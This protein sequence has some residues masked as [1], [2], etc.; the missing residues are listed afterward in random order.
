MA[1]KNRSVETID[2]PQFVNLEPV[3]VNPLM[4]KCD[5]KVFYLGHNRNGSYIDR[6]TALKMAKTL[7]GTPIVAA[8]YEDKGDFGDHGEVMHVENG[9]VTF[10]CKTVPYGFVAPDADVWFQNFEDT[11]EFG[12]SVERTYMMTDGYLWTGQYPEIQKVIDEGQP[13]SMELDGETLSGHWSY[14]SN[15]GVDFFIIN[16]A[17]FSKLCVLGDGV[18]PCFEGSSVTASKDFSLG[19]GFNRTLFSMMEDLK[20]VLAAEGGLKMTDNIKK[21]VDEDEEPAAPADGEEGKAGEPAAAA[22]EEPVSEEPVEEPSAEPVE[23]PAS[24]PEAEPEADASEEAASEDVS[25]EDASSEDVSEE[26]EGDEEGDDPAEDYALVQANETISRLNESLAAAQAELSELRSF[27]LAAENREKDAVIAK[28][29]M[30]DDADKA[31]VVANKEKYTLP[32][33]EAKLAL[34]YVEKNVD[35][36][37]GETVRDDGTKPAVTFSVDEGTHV[38]GLV[39]ALRATSKR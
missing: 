5:V 29:F 12:N 22:A 34:L 31:D 39:S 6:D 26:G 24:E 9:E 18:E 33:I 30:L 36:S 8:W 25:S 3:D 27:K 17:T 19:E 10:S 2:G 23:E 38:S 35:F 20:G 1:L 37:L 11:D 16:D 13:H 21:G 15:L 32:E 4:S 28:Y 14:D 7:R